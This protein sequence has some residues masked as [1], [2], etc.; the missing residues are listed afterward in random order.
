MAHKKILEGLLKFQ[1]AVRKETPITK[2]YL[3]GS[4]VWGKSHKD[5][6]IDILVVSP[7]FRFQK[8]FKRGVH[9]YK[10]CDLKYPVDFLCYTPKEFERF[11][12]SIALVKQVVEK[13]IEITI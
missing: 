9:F 1:Q 7:S 10:Y 11:K 12:K 13:G 4:R 3:F 8:S 5:S 6:D 2:M